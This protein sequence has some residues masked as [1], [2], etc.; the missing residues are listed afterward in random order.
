MPQASKNINNRFYKLISPS[1]RA[2]WE[3]NLERGR[4]ARIERGTALNLI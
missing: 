1:L 3:L 4:I 2:Y